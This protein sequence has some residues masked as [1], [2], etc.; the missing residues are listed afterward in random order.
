MHL[1]DDE[2]ATFDRQILKLPEEAREEYIRQVDYLI[3]S[4][5][6][7][8]KEDGSF[9]VLKFL[10]TGSLRKRTVLKPRDGF[11]VDADIAVYLKVSR[12]F[13]LNTLHHTLCALVMSIYPQ[14]LPEDFQI[15]PRTLGIEFHTS[16][17]E[18]DLVPVVPL[19]N[20]PGDYGLQP[21][22]RNAPP[23][24]TSIP[25]QLKF[26]QKHVDGDPHYRPLVRMLKYW[27]NRQELDDSL[28][29]FAIELIVAHLQD[30]KGPMTSLEDG[31]IR[32]FLFI[33]ETHLKTP[34]A[35]AEHGS[36]PRFPKDPVVILDP[37][38]GDNNV[39]RRITIDERDEI[40]VKALEA[41]E[42]LNSACWKITKGET[43][44]CWRRVFGRTFTI[45]G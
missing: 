36:H 9:G 21:S 10:K 39:T 26:M 24:K 43:I 42:I 20:E 4:L 11:G 19:D 15:Q 22:S 27:R 3:G 1:T 6:E 13:D 16:G 14:K 18:V 23:I 8:I 45:E 30:T 37:V 28:R 40:V 35:F 2:L 32:F 44:T 38:N 29:S 17:L 34:I 5:E 7:K 33:A 25:G 12:D 41:W 31:L